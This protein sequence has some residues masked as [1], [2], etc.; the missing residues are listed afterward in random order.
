MCVL[1]AMLPNPKSSKNISNENTL[2]A[3]YGISVGIGH[4]YMRLDSCLRKL[5]Q[6][7]AWE[8]AMSGKA[9]PAF[10]LQIRGRES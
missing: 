3:W 1:E 8:W 9:L 7:V 10:Q 4:T 6:L 2:T 5:T